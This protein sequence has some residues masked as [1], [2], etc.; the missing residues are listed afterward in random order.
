MTRHGQC[1]HAGEVNT[2]ARQR[3]AVSDLIAEQGGV[4]STKV[5]LRRVTRE[6]IRWHVSSGRWQQPCR[7]V[8]VT[9]S[10]ELTDEQVLRVALMHAG[11][12]AVLA[13]LTA[14]RLDGLTGFGDRSPVREGPVYLLAPL[15]YSRRRAPLDLNVILHYSRQLTAADVHPAREPQRTRIARSLLDAAAWHGS[16]RWALA[17]LTAGVQQRLTRTDHLYDALDRIGHTLPRRELIIEA[18]ADIAGGAQAL[19][20]LDFT[21]KVVRQ[22]RLPEPSRQAG[23]RDE[24]GRQRWIDV[25]WEDWKV[26]VE[27]DGAQ[28]VEARQYWDDM[29][30]ERS[31]DRRLPGPPVPRMAGA[32][33]ARVRRPQDPPCLG[34]AGYA[35][36]HA[37]GTPSVR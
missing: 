9:H 18:L 30:G 32:P 14:A 27:I 1:L 6:A 11:P 13:G 37:R 16:D 28:H 22:F 3:T 7:G 25:V 33:G 34:Q 12:R 10:G 21:R 15:G 36:K 2:Q 4:L 31:H 29:S 17:I 5:L 23:R 35:G 20:E 24:H 19:S 26:I 8:V